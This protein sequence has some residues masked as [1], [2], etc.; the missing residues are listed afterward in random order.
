MKVELWCQEAEVAC[1]RP[2]QL[3]G[4]VELLDQQCKKH[5]V[6]S[7]AARV[8]ESLLSDIGQRAEE[9]MPELSDANQAELKEQLHGLRE[10]MNR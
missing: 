3:D 4:S 10:V 8:H 2:L 7:Q 9:L 6:L 1:S 5:Q